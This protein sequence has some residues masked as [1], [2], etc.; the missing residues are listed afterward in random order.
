MKLMVEKFAHS[1]GLLCR[2]KGF[3]PIHLVTNSTLGVF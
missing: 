2:Y 1:I 3:Y